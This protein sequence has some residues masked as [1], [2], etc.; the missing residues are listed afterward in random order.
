MSQEPPG[1]AVT[2]SLLA[3]DCRSV[4]LL[5]RS[6]VDVRP[7]VGPPEGCQVTWGLP[8]P[9][10]LLYGCCRAVSL[11]DAGTHLESESEPGGHSRPHLRPWA[12]ALRFS[13]LTVL[14]LQILSVCLYE[15]SWDLGVVLLP[16]VTAETFFWS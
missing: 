9:A 12:L 15:D 14:D 10:C 3:L 16:L 5:T 4:V 13:G 11:V 2:R 8:R 1:G 7:A 6:G